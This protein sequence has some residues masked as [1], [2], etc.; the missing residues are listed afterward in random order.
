MLSKFREDAQNIGN[1]NKRRKTEEKCLHHAGYGQQQLRCL[2]GQAS[3][4]VSCEDLFDRVDVS[5]GSQVEAKVEAGTG[6]HD[7]AS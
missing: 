3:V 4:T 1:L 5:S 7:S 2:E 6:L